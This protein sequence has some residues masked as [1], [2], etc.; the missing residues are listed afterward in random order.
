MKRIGELLISLGAIAG[1]AG[2]MN[3]PRN[4]GELY[5]QQ[6]MFIVAGV[7]VIAGV[8]LFVNGKKEEAKK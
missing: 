7:L 8:V 6:N 5:N 1:F 4:F 2:W 3:N